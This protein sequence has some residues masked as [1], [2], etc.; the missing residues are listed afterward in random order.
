MLYSLWGR[1]YK[2]ASMGAEASGWARRRVKGVHMGML[3]RFTDI[4]KANVN[5]LLDRAEDPSKMVDQYLRDLTESLAEVK[6]E[7][8][9]V[10]A[11]EAR[12]ERQVKEN[13]AD[14]SKYDG[15]ARAALEAGNEDDARTFLAK[16]QQLVTKGEGLRAAAEAAHENATKMREMHDKLVGDIEQLKSRREAIKAKVAV[17]KT[18]DKV[19]KMSSAGDRAAGAMSA[20]DR[21]EAK[22]DEML[23]RSNAMS[24]L[25][26]EPADAAAELEKKYADSASTAAVDAELARLKEEMG[27]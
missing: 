21:M 26:S 13:E 27:L 3:D 11:E 20:F 4:I 1:R 6:Q 19:N 5:D 22:A 16:K 8:A 12:T 9:G 23:D 15:L 18:Q 25:S 24:E 2:T 14:I 10:M 7:T 17:A